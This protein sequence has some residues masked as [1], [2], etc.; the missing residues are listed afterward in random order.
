MLLTQMYFL[1]QDYPHSQNVLD[2]ESDRYMYFA[3]VRFICD[4]K[5]GGAPFGE[6]SPILNDISALPSWSKVNRGML[7]M[8]MGEVLHKRPVVQVCA[9]S[10]RRRDC[11]QRNACTLA[12]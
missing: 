5:T 6:H 1:I 9:H 3:A 8:Y 10:I 4:V 12:Y 2:E 11:W 7:K